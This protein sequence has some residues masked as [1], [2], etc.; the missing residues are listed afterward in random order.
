MR[1]HPGY[2]PRHKQRHTVGSLIVATV[3]T[4]AVL[5]A[6]MLATAPAANAAVCPSPA[7]KCYRADLA[8]TTFVA[9]STVQFTAKITNESGGQALG[10]SN[11]TAPTGYTI[12]HLGTPSRGTATQVGNQIQFRNL[13]LPTGSF[14]TLAFTAQ[15]PSSAGSSTWGSTAKQSND[16]NGTG[17]DFVLDPT[18]Q[19]TTTGSPNTA[20]C[21]AGD[22]SCGTNFI[23]YNK[24]SS[25]STGA[26]ANSSAWLVGTINFPATS[27]TGGQFY[28]M[29]ALADPGVCPGSTGPV[30]CT[31]AMQLDTVPAPYDAAHAAKLTLL[32]DQSHCNPNG[33]PTVFKQ[34]DSN[35]TT[36]IPPCAVSPTT[37]CYSF[38]PAGTALQVTVN[39]ITAGDPRVAGINIG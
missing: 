34:D 31:F 23:N 27:V 33:V 28:S 30:P 29:H 35:N 32:C 11:L 14:V 3:A 5:P 19:R 13:A 9:G 10:S 7:I 12:T 4:T 6:V 25:V 36:A 22:V 26:A 20:G 39:N 8:P 16:Y 38:A 2:A 37:L 21:P 24:A 1:M 17:N 18:S 15:T